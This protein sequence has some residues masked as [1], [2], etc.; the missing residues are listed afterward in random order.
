M[1]YNGCMWKGGRLRLEKAKEHY[2]I[3]LRREWQE[4]AENASDASRG[5]ADASGHT[6]SLGKPKKAPSS[7]KMQLQIFFP[8]LKKVSS[9]T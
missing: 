1:Q 4:E 6:V 7:D 3:R 9:L 8:K 2:L 5:N